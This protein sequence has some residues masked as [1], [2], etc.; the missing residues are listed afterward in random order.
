MRKIGTIL[1]EMLYESYLPTNLRLPS[2]WQEFRAHPEFEAFRSSYCA[3]RCADEFLGETI[4]C[5]A[6]L[7]MFLTFPSAAAS[8]YLHAVERGICSTARDRA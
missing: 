8:W 6:D 2:L 7:V 3:R 4:P 5:F 1:L